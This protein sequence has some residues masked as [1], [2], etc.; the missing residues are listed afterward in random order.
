VHIEQSIVPALTL[1]VDAH[2]G[3]YR[4]IWN[5]SPKHM[6]TDSSG[7]YWRERRLQPGLYTDGVSVFESSYRYGD[8]RN[9]MHRISGFR[10]FLNSK[11]IKPDQKQKIIKRL[12]QDA[13]DVVLE[14]S[15]S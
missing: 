4:N 5:F 13:P 2:F 9:G 10:Q 15:P 6:F 7:N 1:I 11:T 12:Q 8:G 3:D 14:L